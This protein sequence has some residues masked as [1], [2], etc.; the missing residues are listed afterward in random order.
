M[1]SVAQLANPSVGTA[2]STGADYII[3]VDGDG[4]PLWVR[5]HD[6]E[7]TPAVLV[8]AD[9]DLGRFL[10]GDGA[11]LLDLEPC[12]LVVLDSIGHVV[13]VVPVA[14]VDAFAAGHTGGE[15]TMGED[16]PEVPGVGGR[17]GLPVARV[18]CAHEDCGVI[19]EV[20]FLDRADP[21]VCAGTSLPPHPLVVSRSR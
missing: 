11:T 8:A 19:N 4:T 2:S 18:A 21:P 12:G 6:G 7:P 20:R 13:G 15:L 3:E 9:Q 1:T 17:I 10:D 5:S 14:A 16:D